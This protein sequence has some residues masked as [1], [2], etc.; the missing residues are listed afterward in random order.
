MC[1]CA[2]PLVAIVA[3]A[4]ELNPPAG[5]IQ[6]TGAV[7][8][9]QQTTSGFPIVV[10]QPGT[11]RLTS[12]ITGVAGADGIQISAS[13]VTLDLN[14][15]SVVGVAGSFNGVRTIVGVD[16]L[17]V[18]NGSVR[19]W[20]ADGVSAGTASGG[21][22]KDLRVAGNG[23]F[24]LNVG[25]SSVCTDCT[26]FQ[27]GSHG[28]NLGFNGTLRGCASNNNMGN[29]IQTGNGAAILNCA[30][31]DNTLVGIATGTG[32]SITSCSAY[33]NNSNG[34]VMIIGSM[35]SQCVSSSNGDNGIL[36]TSD[37]RVMDNCCWGNGTL[38]ANGAGIRTLS[39]DNRIDR[40]T[41]TDNDIGIATGAGINLKLT[42]S[43]S[44]NTTQQQVAVGDTISITAARGNATLPHTNFQ[45]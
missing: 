40:N 17:T 34:F 16:G 20:G 26:T 11:Y 28:L 22:Y 36:V 8:L 41:M 24:G 43:M 5:A 13:G 38:T 10:S 45:F 19:N 6:P 33:S 21:I 44:G 3:H 42:N 31:R 35:I 18:M 23:N 39:S 2:L 15:F 30:A 25:V 37:C 9:N 1:A 12:N 7:L 29:G 14:G 32:S 4:G 27:N